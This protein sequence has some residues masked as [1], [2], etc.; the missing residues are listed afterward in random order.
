VQQLNFYNYYALDDGSAESGYDLFGE[1]T[2]GAMVAQKFY[3]YKT[4]NL[5]GIMIYF[6]RSYQDANSQPFKITVWNDNNGKPGEIIYQQMAS[7]PFHRQFKL[8]HS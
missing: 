7:N 5:V 8:L 3:N 2:I 6:N 1:G 4:D